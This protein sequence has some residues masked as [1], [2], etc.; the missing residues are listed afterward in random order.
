MRPI[1]FSMQFRG[2]ATELDGGVIEAVLTAPS[3]AHL[4][5]VGLDGVDGRFVP[6]PGDEARCVSRLRFDGGASF[7]EEGRISFGRGNVLRF[8]TLAAGS[9]ISTPDPNLTQG[10]AIWEVQGGEGQFEGAQG[11]ITSNFFLSDTGEIT[12]NQFGVVFVEDGTGLGKEK[13]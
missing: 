13:E 2:K 10:T 8:R 12:D 9:A 11:R 6:A 4:T 7:E 1:T 5:T 3:S